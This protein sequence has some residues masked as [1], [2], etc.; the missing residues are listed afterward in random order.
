MKYIL[1]VAI[2]LLAGCTSSDAPIKDTQDMAEDEMSEMNESDHIGCQEGEIDENGNCL[3][4]EKNNNNMFDNPVNVNTQTISQPPGHLAEPATPG[5]YPGVIMIHEWWG[6]ND[7]IK[8]MAEQL[9]DQGYVV[10]AVD[11]YGGEV[12]QD[13]DKARELATSV[14]SNPDDAIQTMREAVDYLEQRTDRVA[15]LG[16]CFGG[17]QSLQLSLNDELD[18]T[19]IYYGNLVEDPEQ[20]QSL[21][22][23]VLGI[24]GAEDSGIPVE[25]VRN[26]ESALN[27][28]NVQNDITIYDGVGHAFANPSGSNYAP[29]E[30]MD[31]WEKTLAF[32]EANLKQP[33]EPMSE[34]TK[35]DVIVTVEGVDF[36]FII[37]G[38]EEPTIEVNEGDLVRID[39]SSTQGYH[40]WV[41]D[42]FDAATQKVQPQDGM[43]SVEFVADQA[44]TFEFY[45]SVGQHRQQGMVGTLVVN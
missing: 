21:S 40:D 13:S 1:L 5:D 44:G 38:Q 10:F 24:F 25:S 3:P 39:F 16:W 17:Q 32:L 37:D 45:C 35:P 4:A 15:S 2:L 12:A 7:N 36:D 14:R 19:I 30:T 6:L 9:A 33:V 29:E 20:L 42:E 31:A 27:Q 26:F 34:T 22:G 8:N 23:P 28:I 18:A 41:V 11:L 43:T